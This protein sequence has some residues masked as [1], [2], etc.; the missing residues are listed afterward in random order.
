[1][2]TSTGSNLSTKSRRIK[3]MTEKEKEFIA[4][5]SIKNLCCLLNATS[6]KVL[7]VDS[8]GK[9]MTKIIITIDDD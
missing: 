7:S 8:T 1:M 6:S 9:T 3:R 2:S 4:D 5:I